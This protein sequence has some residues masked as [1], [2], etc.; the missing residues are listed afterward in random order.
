[1]ASRNFKPIRN[2]KKL[3][4]ARRAALD[5]A[6]PV[7]TL[8]GIEIKQQIAEQQVMLEAATREIQKQGV[9]CESLQT[10]GK[11]AHPSVGTRRMCIETIERLYKLLGALQDDDV[12]DEDEYV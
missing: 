2:F 7:N 11:Y 1:L 8:R 6:Y 3:V 4:D 5:E 10:G 9:T 12:G